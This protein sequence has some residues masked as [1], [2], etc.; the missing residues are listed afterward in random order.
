VIEDGS[1]TPTASPSAAASET[2]IFIALLL[3][4]AA[5]FFDAVVAKDL[6]AQLRASRYAVTEGV[7]TS[8]RVASDS[9]G[10][11]YSIAVTYTYSVGGRALTGD[12]YSADDGWFSSGD[13]AAELVRALPPGTRVPVH[14]ASDDPKHAVL[15]A[16][17]AGGD[18]LL[19][20]PA[21]S[22]TLLSISFVIGARR[23]RRGLPDPRESPAARRELEI[24]SVVA[25]FRAELVGRT[26]LRAAVLALAVSSLGALF[27]ILAT[28]G[29]HP[30]LAVSMTAWGGSA[31]AALAAAA[32][33]RRL[34]A[35]AEAYAARSFS[36]S[37]RGA[38]TRKITPS[39]V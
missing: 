7:V 16:G 13:W 31:T 2:L 34:R 29:S 1:A 14:Y 24:P 33:S 17:L 32:F 37:A 23:K 28:L 39:S 12:H 26:P 35:R 9:E 5:L 6:A 30:P 27:L 25:V 21:V 11:V 3:L 10:G 15:R 36:S 19:L 8:S 38:R 20:M 18:L 22:A 4:A